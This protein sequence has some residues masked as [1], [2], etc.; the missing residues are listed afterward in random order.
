MY[1]AKS[2]GK[3]RA[4][5]FEPAMHAA[6]VTRLEL[7]GDLERALEE[8][9]L[10]IRYQ[11]VF[12]LATGRLESFEALLRWRHPERGEVAPDEFIPVAEETGLIV[13]IG[14]WVLEQACLQAQAWRETG[15][16]EISVG[17]N[18]SSRQLREPGIVESVAASLEASGLPAEHLVLELTETG[19]MQEDDGRLHALRKLGVRLALDD[20]GTGYSS[21]SYLA[22]FPIDF[23]KIDRSFI[24][25]LGTVGEDSALV[26]SVIQLASALKLRTVAEG[27]ERPDQL[28]RLKRLGCDYGQ[29]FLYAR[30]MDAI[31]ATRLVTDPTSI[32]DLPRTDDRDDAGQDD[33]GDSPLAAAG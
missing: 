1:T 29:G 31:R 4:E 19:I 13:P 27:I 16:E 11:P 25:R 5:T 22:R 8:E 12:H 10:R 9:Q 17:V 32:A 14:R 24:A 23:L 18:L 2:R 30:P 26:R 6:V 3:G 15:N 20:F 33:T 21:L 28:Q 7:R